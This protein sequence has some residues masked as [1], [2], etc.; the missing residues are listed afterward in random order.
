MI[1]CSIAL[2]SVIIIGISSYY[3]SKEVAYQQRTI[4]LNNRGLSN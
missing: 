1:I 2:W 4:E 3:I